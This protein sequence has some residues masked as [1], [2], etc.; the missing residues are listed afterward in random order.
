FREQI[1]ALAEAGADLLFIET[2][3]DL[4]QQLLALDVAK[5]A[6][7]LPVVCQM[8]FHE[9]GHTYAGVHAITAVEALTQAKADVLGA[10]CGRGVRCVAKAIEIMTARTDLPVS[11]FPN[12]GLPEYVEG[13]YLFGAPLPY[14]V[15]S[16]VGMAEHGVNL[17]GGCCGTTPAYVA[18]IAERLK[19]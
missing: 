8:A 16:A 14:L 4:H 15:D 17:I 13:R 12:A 3:S 19:G 9:R 2:F 1:I 10:N 6:T 5:T 7:D 11:A 18:R